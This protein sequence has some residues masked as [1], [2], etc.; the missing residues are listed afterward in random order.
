[1]KKFEIE[2]RDYLAAKALAAYIMQGMSYKVAARESY[3]MA[4]QM[5]ESR[6]TSR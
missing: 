3:K 5:L 1:M 2:L 4:D 6:L